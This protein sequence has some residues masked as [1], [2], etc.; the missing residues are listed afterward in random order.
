MDMCRVVLV[1]RN[2]KNSMKIVRNIRNNVV[3]TTKNFSFMNFGQLGF[4]YV[5]TT[6]KLTKKS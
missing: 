5:L 1:E 4:N 3:M 6:K 2:S